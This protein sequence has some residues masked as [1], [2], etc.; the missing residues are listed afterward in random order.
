MIRKKALGILICCNLFVSFFLC[1]SDDEAWDKLFNANVQASLTKYLTIKDAIKCSWINKRWQKTWDEPNIRKELIRKTPGLEKYLKKINLQNLEISFNGINSLKPIF[2]NLEI[3]DGFVTSSVVAISPDGKTYLG[4]VFDKNNKSRAARWSSTGVELFEEG[5]EAFDIDK[6][7]SILGKDSQGHIIIRLGDSTKIFNNLNYQNFSYHPNA[8]SAHKKTIIGS[9]FDKTLQTLKGFLLS[10]EGTFA[11][12]E[13]PNFF[14]LAISED[15]HFI[16]GYSS[17]SFRNDSVA[18]WTENEG[19]KDII[20][21]TENPSIYNSSLSN[22]TIIVGHRGQDFSEPFIWQGGKTKFLFF[23]LCTPYS[24]K[25]I[26]GSGN[27]IAG[28]VDHRNPTID[29]KMPIWIKNQ[30]VNEPKSQ[31]IASEYQFY[32]IIFPFMYES[33]TPERLS[34]NGSK[35]IGN[36]KG[37]EGAK[38]FC[39]HLPPYVALKEQ[40]LDLLKNQESIKAVLC[41]EKI[42]SYS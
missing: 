15:S 14:P 40:G 2:E 19:V 25:V 26:S 24:A 34:A 5:F 41:N 12:F 36:F 10:F 37:K 9:C 11:T 23:S 3:P 17:V 28:S 39:L 31:T 42:K 33:L 8:I 6:E 20:S 35:I 13:N 1:A 38:A 21:Y 29:N 16:A 4:K 7:G 32:K 22:N 27:I 18:V 30:D